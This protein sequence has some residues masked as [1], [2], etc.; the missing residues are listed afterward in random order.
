MCGF[1]L[2]AVFVHLAACSPVN[3]MSKSDVLVTRPPAGWRRLKAAFWR[4]SRGR[5]AGELGRRGFEGRG[6]PHSNATSGKGEHAP[7]SASASASA[8]MLKTT[9]QLPLFERF[10]HFNVISS[11]QP[12]CSV[13]TGCPKHSTHAHAH[14]PTLSDF[15]W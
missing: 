6:S 3:V 9:K 12:R 11:S 10:V 8:S 15:V 14:A 13:G 7:A 1:V 4:S 5:R 2:E